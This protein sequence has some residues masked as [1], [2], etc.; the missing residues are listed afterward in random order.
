MGGREVLSWPGA[1][2]AE[3]CEML[4]GRVSWPEQRRAGYQGLT[5][6]P[7]LAA[8]LG[9]LCSV[10]M[11]GAPSL[12]WL[13][14]VTLTDGARLPWHRDAPRGATHKL[15]VHLDN[16]AGTEFSDTDAAVLGLGLGPFDVVLEAGGRGTIV[17]FDIQLVHRAAAC[18]APRRRILGLRAI[19]GP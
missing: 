5:E 11:I 18:D 12:R 7:A 1:F 3:E 19:V 14:D 16:A 15:C 6:D 9:E 17:L 10:R 8:W 4:A 2:S 13:A